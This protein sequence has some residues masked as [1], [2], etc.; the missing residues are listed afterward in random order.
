M[1]S[2]VEAR[3]AGEVLE[4]VAVMTRHDHAFF[5]GYFDKVISSLPSARVRLLQLPFFQGRVGAG[6]QAHHLFW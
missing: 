5:P 3:L 4:Q 1:A 2:G 6:Q